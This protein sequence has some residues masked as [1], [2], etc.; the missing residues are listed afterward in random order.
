MRV[1]VIQ[2]ETRR[3]T[4]LRV[5]MKYTEEYCKRHGYLYWCPDAEYDMPTYWVKVHLVQQAMTAFP[6][7]E[8]CVAW[9][10]SDAVFVRPHVRI[11]DILANDKDFV[12]SLDPGS[13]TNM[14]A[15]VFFIRRTQTTV[16]LMKNWFACY[17]ITRWKKDKEGKW[18]TEGRWAGP[19]YEQGS[20]NERILPKYQST[21]SLQPESVFACYEAF[22][23]PNTIV[24]HFM[25]NHKWKIW[26]FHAQQQVPEVLL[27]LTLGTSLALLV[28]GKN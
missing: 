11:E 12:T 4:A 14:N 17:D 5:L 28:I 3:D 23:E 26:L 27:W 24:C 15:G 10:D 2:Y 22:Y 9:L 19:D 1:I 6:N 21:I 13:N 20:F 16:Q 8:L 25:Y 7:E 18:S